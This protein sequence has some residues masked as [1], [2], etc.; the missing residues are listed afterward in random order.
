VIGTKWISKNELNDG[1]KVVRNK[2]RLVCKGYSQVKGIYFEETFAFVARLESINMFFPFAR[3]KIF[4]VYQM[5]VK[6]IFL[7]GYLEEYVYI[8][9]PE[10]FLLS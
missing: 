9:Q 8:E 4:K 2:A 10:G 7:N 6:S 1:G 3:F 5:N